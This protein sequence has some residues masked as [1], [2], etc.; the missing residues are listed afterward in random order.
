[1]S[2]KT[3]CLV[4]LLAVLVGALSLAQTPVSD[5]TRAAASRYVYFWGDLGV[6]LKVNRAT[7]AIDS[8][9]SLSST[10]AASVLPTGSGSV[11]YWSFSSLRYDGLRTLYAL[12]ATNP[13]NDSNPAYRLVAFNMPDFSPRAHLDLPLSVVNTPSL[14]L[15]HDRT[16]LLLGYSEGHHG[17]TRLVID[18][19]DL[20]DLKKTASFTEEEAG[21][22]VLK[23]YFGRKAYFSDDGKL[24][25]EQ[26]ERIPL[27]GQSAEREYVNP[28]KK[29][30]AIERRKLSQFEEIDIATK[31]PWVRFAVTGSAGGNAL[32]QVV[33]WKSKKL[34]FWVVDLADGSTSSV[35]VVPLGKTSLSDDGEV[36]IYE[37]IEKTSNTPGI[38]GNDQENGDIR[39]YGARDGRQTLATRLEAVTGKRSGHRVLCLAPDESQLFFVAGKKLGVLDTKTSKIAIVNTAFTFGPKVG[40]EFASR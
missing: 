4:G 29:L 25:L 22:G 37:G 39:I 12:F 27:P 5:D 3:K 20:P 28:L 2:K 6:F 18:T 24:I 9:R 36:V 23:H 14:L 32:V 7:L 10:K 34:A 40:C 1:M 16:K 15:T 13:G 19:Y 38:S 35:T 8:Q 11:F 33:N 26:L 21:E 17:K 30:P 31:R